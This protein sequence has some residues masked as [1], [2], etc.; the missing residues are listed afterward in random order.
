MITYSAYWSY[1]EMRL[2]WVNGY[3]KPL[4]DSRMFQMW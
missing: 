1:F 3:F 2:P 4:E